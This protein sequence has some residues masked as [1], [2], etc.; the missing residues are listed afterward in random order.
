[1]ARY[2]RCPETFFSAIMLAA[3]V[4]FWPG[5][6]MSLG[7]RAMNPIVPVINNGNPVARHSP[8]GRTKTFRPILRKK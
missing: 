1:A 4:L 5:K 6:A 7:P 8:P 3:T 2:D